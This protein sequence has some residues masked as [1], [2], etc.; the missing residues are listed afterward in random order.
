MGIFKEIVNF[1]PDRF[2]LLKINKIF[3]MPNFTV[4]KL[5]GGIAD[6]F[7]YPD[8]FSITLY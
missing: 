6:L 7:F 5:F 1:I 8:N 4:K 2:Q 3:G